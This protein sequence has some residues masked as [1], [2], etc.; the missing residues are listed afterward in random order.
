MCAGRSPHQRFPSSRA[1]RLPMLGVTRYRQPFGCRSRC[2]CR[3][4]PM[5]SVKCSMTSIRVTAAKDAAGSDASSRLPVLTF[6]FNC[7]R[8]YFRGLL[9][10]LDALDI[11][12]Q[13]RRIQKVSRGAANIEKTALRD[14]R[15]QGVEAQMSVDAPAGTFLAVFFV[16]SEERRVGKECRCRCCTLGVEQKG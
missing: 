8:A 11:V 9:R 14:Q 15:H 6:S 13:A 1:V 5:G 4:A 2:A 3:S 10:R 16:R 7:S 12:V